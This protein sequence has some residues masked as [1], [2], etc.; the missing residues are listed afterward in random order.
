[1]INVYGMEN[2]QDEM[3]KE[4][5]GVIK[6]NDIIKPNDSK[7]IDTNTQKNMKIDNTGYFE[8]AGPRFLKI[9]SDFLEHDEVRKVAQTSKT[10]YDTSARVVFQN[11]TEEKLLHHL[12]AVTREYLE[13]SYSMMSFERK[14]KKK[15]E[16]EC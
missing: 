5:C 14:Y 7:N 8:K 11:K 3:D 10:N 4:L 12:L 13:T 2:V 16:C 6:Q 15:K 1:M 9:T